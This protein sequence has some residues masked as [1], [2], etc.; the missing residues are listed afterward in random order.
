LTE[1]SAASLAMQW[2]EN[3]SFIN[4]LGMRV[5]SME[6]DV[7]RI[8]LPYREELTTLADVVHGGAISSLIDTAAAAAAWSG[9]EGVETLRGTTVSLTVQFL[10]AA[11]SSDLTAEARVIRRGKNLCFCEI[12]VTDPAGSLAAKGV[13]TYKLG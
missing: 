12:D 1:T 13:V 7:A 5:L 2:L 3:S 4:H 9:A 10:A 11:R 8:L 6:K